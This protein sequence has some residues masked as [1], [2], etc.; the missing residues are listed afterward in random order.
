[1]SALDDLITLVP[2]PE[3][4]PPIGEWALDLPADYRA[5]IERY[6]PGNLAGLRLLVPGHP[7][8]DLDITRQVQRQ[9]WA[10][11]SLIDQGIRMPYEPK[12][13]LPWGIDESG[14]VVWWHTEGDWDV[15]ANEA[16]GPEW[17]RH[18]GGA[19]SFLVALLS[20]RETSDFLVI[21]GDDFEPYED[22]PTS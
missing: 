1:M 14:N 8:E 3:S 17:H 15:V 20:G 13:L 10:L 12:D 18:D 19:V 5:L 7:R 16:R 6:G 2:P 21:E 4:P 22:T 11:Q 9:R